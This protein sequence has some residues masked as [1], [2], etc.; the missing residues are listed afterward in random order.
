MKT[1]VAHLLPMSLM[2]LL[3]ALTLW[4]QYAVLE[5]SGGNA[6]P[7]AG[8][9]PDG[10]VENFSVQRLDRSGRLQYTFSAPKMVHFADDGSGEVLYPRLVQISD[11][12]GN[13]TASANR[14]TINRQGEE[15]F[16]YGNV[17]ISREATPQQPE[18]HARTEFL[19]VLPEQ[20]ISRTDHT[21]TITEGRSILTGVGMVVDKNRRQFT[22][23]SQVKGIFSA[24]NRK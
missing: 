7:A 21:V 24:P 19:H 5:G 15:A 18:F 2:L 10:I 20:G 22:L 13:V 16:L 3:A 9:D 12:G 17:L 11:D 8:H 14:G 6:K 1:R 23:Q 4:L